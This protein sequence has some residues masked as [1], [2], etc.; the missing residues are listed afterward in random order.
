MT[1]T[2]ERTD[3]IAEAVALIDRGLTDILHREL[4][5]TD[6][7]AN[8]LLDMRSV[9]VADLSEELVGDSAN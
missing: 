5:S 4:V 8:L 7:M 1:Q 9:L 2:Q 6:E 3:V